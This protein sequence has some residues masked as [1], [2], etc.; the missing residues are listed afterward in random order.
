MLIITH[1]GAF[2]L[3]ALFG[4]W[5]KDIIALYKFYNKENKKNEERLENLKKEFDKD[6]NKYGK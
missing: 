4:V 2:G 3:G 6:W 1:I 5:L